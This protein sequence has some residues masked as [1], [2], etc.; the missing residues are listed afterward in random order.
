MALTSPQFSPSAAASSPLFLLPAH[1]GMCVLLA[2]LYSP[3]AVGVEALAPSSP[4]T[5]VDTKKEGFQIA[6][7][8]WEFLAALS[9]FQDGPLGTEAF[10][11]PHCCLPCP[12]PPARGMDRARA[13]PRLSTTQQEKLW[14]TSRGHLAGDAGSSPR[15]WATALH[16]G[17]QRLPSDLLPVRPWCTEGTV[18][19]EWG[20]NRVQL[21]NPQ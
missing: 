8:R 6:G 5:T 11:G 4:H 18:N 19:C 14:P 16:A 15:L 12:S 21:D 13:P 17:T 7:A 20:G 3:V 1:H 2:P 9:N 10:L